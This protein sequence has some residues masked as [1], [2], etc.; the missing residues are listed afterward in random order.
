MQLVTIDFE[1]YWSR[2]YSLSKLSTEDYVY[3][4]RFE[5]ILCSYKVGAAPTRWITGTHDEV[6]DRLARIVTPDVAVLG[7][8]IRFDGMVLTRLGLPAPRMWLCTRS[9]AKAQLG[10]FIP[11]VGLHECLEFLQLPFKKGTA[12]QWACGL[13]RSD[14]TTDQ[15]QAYAEYCMNDTEATHA[16]F[17]RLARDFPPTEFFTVDLTTRM[18]TEPALELDADLLREIEQEAEQKQAERLAK[19]AEIAPPDVLAS[20]Q[21]FAG[22]L[23]ELGIDVPM[24]V[25]PQT[26]GMI[27][28]LAKQD[29]GFKD[30][31]EDYAHDEL[32]TALLDARRGQKS[33]QEA[34]R[35]RRLRGIALRYKRL[36]VPLLYCSAHT[37]RYGGDES[38]NL[39]NLP[40]VYNSRLRYAVE[41]PP[42]HVILAADLSQIEARWYAL[43]AQQLDLL[44]QFARGEDP[45]SIFASELFH[46][47]IRKGRDT[48]ERDIGKEAILSMGFGVSAPAY[49]RRLR[50]QYNII[51]T[52]DESERYVET[53][54]RTFSR[55]PKYWTWLK[56][57]IEDMAY[58]AEIQIGPCCTFKHGIRGPDG[59]ALRYPHLE[60][61]PDG[62]SYL[63][64]GRYRKRLYGAKLLEN[65]CQYLAQRLLVHYEREIYRLT[66]LRVKLQVHDEMVFVVPEKHAEVY[67]KAI[68]LIITRNVPSWAAGLPVA[69]EV[70]WARDYGSVK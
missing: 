3:D 15:L 28:A 41:A 42:G 52:E 57:R 12:T 40:R 17:C 24:K 2:E 44:G 46:R 22:L 6:R 18:Y 61:G 67:A 53:Y 70:G 32:V 34:T 37:T 20:N 55:L 25:S 35:A 51:I 49:R 47:E 10:Q 60:E 4:D 14:F 29:P 69:C 21:K 16:L 19:V 33:R 64:K 43:L 68:R 9:M 62:W 59:T 58:G 5:V 63:S 39:Q 1:T 48:R 26:G 30:L 65:L 66:S 7:H 54:R 56:H 13:R 50:G 38:I 11:R 31:C 8:N 27:P 45:Y 23:T 36:R